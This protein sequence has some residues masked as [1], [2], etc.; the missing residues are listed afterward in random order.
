VGPLKKTIFIAAIV[1][2]ACPIL[3]WLLVARP[4]L[5]TTEPE[6]AVS[7]PDRLRKHVEVLSVKVGAR[8][9]TSPGLDRAAD[10]ISAT[11]A[12]EGLAP[13]DQTF[14]VGG[15]AF[16][17]IVVELGP[18]EGAKLVFGAHYDTAGRLPG[19]DDNA[20]GVAG[21]LE[22]GRA[23]KDVELERP[24]TLV[25]YTLEEP[26]FFA[27]EQMGSFVH[28]SAESAAGAEIDLM[29]SIEMIGYFSEDEGSQSYPLGLLGLIYPSRGNF[30]AVIDRMMSNSSRRVKVA[31]AEKI[32]LPV[33]SMNAPA[34]LT[35]VDFSDHRN[36]WAHGYDAVMVTDT[37]FYRN[38]HYH[39]DRDTLDRLDFDKMAQVVDGL[40]WFARGQ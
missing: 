16:R 38:T 11:F 9:Y 5:V 13:L 34:A 6:A 28:A 24:V 17:N 22:L 33:Y 7:D 35:G 30:I 23:L 36:Y 4:A 15:R 1:A 18:K 21:L 26:P 2:V 39:T 12:S 40:V 31:M 25:A 20:S 37:S 27:T 32:S 14:E 8:D 19:A 10:Y 29:V 3:L